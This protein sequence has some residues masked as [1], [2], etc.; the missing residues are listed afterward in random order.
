[1]GAAGGHR[2]P[3]TKVFGPFFASGREGEKKGG[4][5]SKMMM[6]KMS[7]GG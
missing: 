3:I 4:K 7:Y 5:V 6:M 1:M 2:Q